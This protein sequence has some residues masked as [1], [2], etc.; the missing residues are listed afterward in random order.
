V[1][2]FTEF[3]REATK[4]GLVVNIQKTK[5][6]IASR[7][8]KSFKE[9]TKIVIEGISYERTDTFEYLGTILNE[10]D[11]NGNGYKSAIS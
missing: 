9:V 5:Y 7:N 3:T 1:L 10:N 6:M 8:M 11:D 2:N 4:L